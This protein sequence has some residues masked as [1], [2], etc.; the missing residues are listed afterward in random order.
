MRP[1]DVPLE[2]YIQEE[3]ALGNVLW[4]INNSL[5]SLYFECIGHIVGKPEAHLKLTILMF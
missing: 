4:S 1:F 2:C 3:M 5:A